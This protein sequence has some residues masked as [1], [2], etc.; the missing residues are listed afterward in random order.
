MLFVRDAVEAAHETAER[1][2]ARIVTACGFDSIPSD[3]GVHLLYREAER[4]GLGGLGDTT[5]LVTSLSGGF[6]GGTIDTM[7]SQLEALEADPS[8]RKVVFDPFALSTIA[9]PSRTARG[10]A[11]R[12]TSSGTRPPAGGRRRG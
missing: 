1:T 4:L 6:S 3:L 10:S 9:P 5:L 12:C 2:G 11:T 7:R 8:R